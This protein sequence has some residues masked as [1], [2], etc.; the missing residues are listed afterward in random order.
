MRWYANANDK[1]HLRRQKDI[2]IYADKANPEQDMRVPLTY[3]ER[4]I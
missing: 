1:N 4:R 3:D 2:A